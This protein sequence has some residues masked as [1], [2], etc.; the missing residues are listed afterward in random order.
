MLIRVLFLLLLALPAHAADTLTGRMVVGYQGWFDCPDDGFGPRVWRHWFHRD[1]SG[2]LRPTFDLWPDMREVPPEEHCA[3]GLVKPDGRPAP[4]F[5]SENPATVARHVRWMAEHGIEA[6][7]LQ[8]FIGQF[9]DPVI[10]AGADRVMDNLAAAAITHRRSWFV[11]Y[12][13]SGL[14]EATAP[15]VLAEFTRFA[16]RGMLSHPAYQ[17]HDGRPVV[18]LWGMGFNGR[19]ATAADWRHV[20]DAARERLGDV[21]LLIGVPAWWREGVRDARPGPEWQALYAR[22]HILSPW[23]VG[24][25]GDIASAE[26]YA[27]E[28]LSRDH[29]LARSRG[30]EVMPVI[31]P[32][33]SWAN[34]MEV[35]G[36]PGR[37]NHI[38]R[39]CGAFYWAQARA[40]VNGG[41]R[42]LYTAMFDELD[43]G[44]AILPIAPSR[45]DTPADGRFLAADEDG[46]ALPS[47]WYLR[48]A[49]AV[50]RGLAEGRLPEAMPTP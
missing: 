30:Q 26:R 21:T 2:A 4:L 31:F 34:L 29:A 50:Q 18:G 8:R 6:A 41:A 24:R 20:L 13:L 16:A 39:R 36:Q 46:C 11:M 7:A 40:V 48:L 12:D 9:R 37:R 47:D 27:R 25:F 35:R 42:L 3:T 33:F 15:A 23:A 17:R 14:T 5:S 45:A 32:G 38:P 1:A 28:T 22:A 44:T 10:R 49:G 19:D 43:E